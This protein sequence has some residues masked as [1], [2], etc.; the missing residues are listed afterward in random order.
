MIDAQQASLATRRLSSRLSQARAIAANLP[1]H[2]A[3]AAPAAPSLCS[4]SQKGVRSVVNRRG[5]TGV[6]A[7][8]YGKTN[9]QQVP[10]Q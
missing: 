3:H 5:P 2:A 9:S 6:G 4:Q 7:R 1:S 8:E 10:F